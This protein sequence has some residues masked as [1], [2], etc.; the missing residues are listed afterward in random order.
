MW[1][2]TYTGTLAW[3]D[4]GEEL[5]SESLS[6]SLP[7]SRRNA[8]ESN[9][10][11]SS[12][13]LHRLRGGTY[14]KNGMGDVS[15]GINDMTKQLALL[16]LVLL[17]QYPREPFSSFVTPYI[18]RPNPVPPTYCNAVDARRA[19]ATFVMLARNSDVDSAVHAVRSVEDRFNG[20]Y[21]YP[22]VFLNEQ[23][24]SNDFKRY[25]RPS[26][27][28]PSYE[29]SCMLTP[30]PPF[31]TLVACQSSPPGLCISARSLQ[32]TGI[33]LGGSMRQ[34]RRRREIRCRRRISYTVAVYR[35]T[36]LSHCAVPG[37]S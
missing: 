2:Y 35:A 13:S 15:A 28:P 19:N 3:Q 26:S 21:N 5:L 12:S 16:S 33:S 18:S 25:T 32:G 34:G 11:N 24:F 27:Q 36:F 1:V 20:N 30:V 6:H 31:H 4:I 23:P 8:A 29:L 7:F 9:K 14:P 37:W 17:T 10:N 22:W